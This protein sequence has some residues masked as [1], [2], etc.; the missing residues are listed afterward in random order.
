[1]KRHK[2]SILAVLAALLWGSLSATPYRP[3]WEIGRK[4]GSAAEFALYD[5]AY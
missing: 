5:D 4:D 2:H 3:V 1:M